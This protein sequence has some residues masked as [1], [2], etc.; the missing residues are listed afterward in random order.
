M[1]LIES[2]NRFLIAIVVASAAG[3]G[4]G[5]LF[6]LIAGRIAREEK[7]EGIE[8]S[9]ALKAL[10]SNLKASKSESETS[11]STQIALA[12]TNLT[13][14]PKRPANMQ[15]YDDISTFRG[16]RV[17]E[18]EAFKK[19]GGKVVG[20]FCLFV[21]TE[22]ICASGA[23]P[24]RLDGGLY[25]SVAPSEQLLPSDACPVAKSALGTEMLELSP[26]FKLCDVLVCP[27]S[28]DMKS[29]LG[30]MF[31]EFAPVWRLEVPRYK[32]EPWT[33]SSWQNQIN[34]FKN[35]LEKLT[36][37]RITGKSLRRSVESAQQRERFFTDFVN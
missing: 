31:D 29:K 9:D 23:L 14:Q 16:K 17:D 3:L 27:T 15:Y 25:C 13:N 37:N 22:L 20:Y 5:W 18:V 4:T 8:K 6:L 34:S 11:A 2:L 32:D 24:L 30:D 7:K 28:C 10:L 1:S 26:Y 21:P 19:A 33:Q 12:I 35:N 36:G